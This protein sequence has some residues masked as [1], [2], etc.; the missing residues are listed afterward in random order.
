MC[1]CVCLSA[2]VPVSVSVS[3]SV[4]VPV[5]VPVSISV[6][7]SVPVSVWICQRS[8]STTQFSTRMFL[9]VDKNDKEV[10]NGG[11]WTKFVKHLSPYFEQSTEGT[12][13]SSAQQQQV[14][15]RAL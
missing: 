15:N 7:V 6:P 3:V 2:S 11:G 1:V 13:F 4:P 9:K 10:K 5:P 12:L 14:L 8:E